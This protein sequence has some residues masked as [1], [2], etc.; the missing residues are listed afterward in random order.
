MNRLLSILLTLSCLQFLPTYS[1]ACINLIDDNLALYRP[2]R[3]SYLDSL[4]YAKT[5]KAVS[6]DK[7][8]FHC[9]W[10]VPREFSVKQ[11]AVLKSIIV[12]HQDHLDNLE[13]N[14]WSN[15]DLF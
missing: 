2:D 5:L 15:V 1:N 11:V 13:V 10:R 14:L 12:S 8:I 7:L 6:S 3:K 4:A 9:F